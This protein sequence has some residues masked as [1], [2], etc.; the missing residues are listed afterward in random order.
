V[1]PLSP[2]PPYPGTEPEIPHVIVFHPPRR[3]YVIHAALFILTIFT[4]LVV[5]ARMMHNWEVGSPYFFSDD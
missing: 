3:P 5:G 4:T 2:L 1:D